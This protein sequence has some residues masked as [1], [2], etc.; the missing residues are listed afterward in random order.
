MSTDVEATAA[1]SARNTSPTGVG[2]I[3][4]QCPGGGQHRTDADR[5][6]GVLPAG[7]IALRLQ[8]GA[9]PGPRN[10]RLGVFGW[11][12]FLGM[13]VATGRESHISIDVVLRLLGPRSR[14]ALEF[15]GHAVIAAVSFMLLVHGWDYVSRVIS[16]SPA[17]ATADEVFSSSPYRSAACSISSSSAGRRRGARSSTASASSPPASPLYLAGALRWAGGLRPE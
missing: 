13:A 4:A 16:A 14:A 1:G 7:H 11:S 9:C 5:R 15:F 17:A 2:K 12:V 8:L 6:R 3:V 10:W